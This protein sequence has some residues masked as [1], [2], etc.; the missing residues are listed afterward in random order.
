MS[1]IALTISFSIDAQTS[2]RPPKKKLPFYCQNILAAV[3]S[4]VLV[5]TPALLRDI[6]GYVNGTPY[7]GF[8]I[9]LDSNH[10]ESLLSPEELTLLKDKKDHVAIAE[11]F[12][13][14]LMGDY[15]ETLGSRREFFP[16]SVPASRYFK[17]QAD[18]RGACRHKACVL[19]GILNSYGIKAEFR[20]F[21]SSKNVTDLGHAVVYLT[22]ENLIIDPTDESLNGRA[23]S[24]EEFQKIAQE[25]NLAFKPGSKTDMGAWFDYV[26]QGIMR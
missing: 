25:R 19:N 5:S 18:L 10:I 21:F 20:G 26:Q 17:G 16:K 12:A 8:G 7:L 15:D 11:M 24:I 13:R 3:G 1:L 22:D 6:Q 2:A 14:K 9:F 4:V 23:I